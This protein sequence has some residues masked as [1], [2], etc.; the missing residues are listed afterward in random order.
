[1]GESSKKNNGC[2]RKVCKRLMD[3]IGVVIPSYNQ[4]AFLGRTLESVILQKR[5]LPLCVVV[6]DGSSTDGSKAIIEEYKDEL[7][8]YVCEK[9]R[10][11]AHAI[12]KGMQMLDRRCKYVCW[13][14]SDDVFLKEGLIKLY[15]ALSKKAAAGMVYSNAY[16][17]DAQDNQIGTYATSNTFDYGC[18]V[19]Q[20][21]TLIKREYWN[22]LNGLDE[23]FNMCMDM[24]MW[25]RLQMMGELLFIEDFTACSREHAGTKTKNNQDIHYIESFRTLKQNRGY[26]SK[27]WVL[28]YYAYKGRNNGLISKIWIRIKYFYRVVLLK[29]DY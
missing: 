29:Q 1:M 15:N 7:Y 4:A 5:D 23:T 21:A 22:K 20:P 26:I 27:H 6:V 3:M 18:P 13:L 8:K 11:Q 25:L 9:D 2:L 14:N 19:C 28:S 12:N 24:D 10:G 17:I 16:I